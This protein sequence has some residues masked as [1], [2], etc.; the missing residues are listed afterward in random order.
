MSGSYV[1]AA[2]RQ[3]EEVSMAVWVRATNARLGPETENI[4]NPKVS[5]SAVHDKNRG[6]K[7]VASVG[8]G[9]TAG[10]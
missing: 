3:V 10:A 8:Q 7:E 9:W 1:I 2:A 6:G 5:G 4:V